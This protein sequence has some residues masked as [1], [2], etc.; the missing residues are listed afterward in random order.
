MTASGPTPP[1]RPAPSRVLVAGAPA[2][3]SVVTDALQAQGHLVVRTDDVTAAG[4][5]LAAAFALDVPASFDTDAWAA[6]LR[7]ANPQAPVA[8]AWSDPASATWAAQCARWVERTT[9]PEPERWA[10]SRR[11]LGALLPAD[12]SAASAARQLVRAVDPPTAGELED[13]VV[14]AASELASNAARHG[15]PPV[16]LDVVVHG[17]GVYLGVRDDGSGRLPRRRDPSRFDEAGRGLSIVAAV[18][19]WWGV[20]ALPDE[21]LVWCDVRAPE[22]SDELGLAAATPG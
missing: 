6:E 12:A 17:S 19:D 9:T 15:R 13:A 16:R 21:V 22:V 2:S 20:T 18:A 1:P 11:H 8:F 4:D 3:A 5:G 14:L 10:W 7:R